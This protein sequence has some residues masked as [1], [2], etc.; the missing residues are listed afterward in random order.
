MITVTITI[1]GR[2]L[3]SRTAVN[4]SP[5]GTLDSSI[6]TYAVDDGSVIKHRRNL[7]AV[8]LAKKMLDTIKEP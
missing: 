8:P 1:N 4:K 6:T 3:Y 7:G 5:D 2:I